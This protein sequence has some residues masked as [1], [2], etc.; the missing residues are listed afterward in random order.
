MYNRYDRLEALRIILSNHTAGSQEDIL[1]ELRGYGHEVTQATLSRDL[2][3]LK[4]VKV[5]SAE[6]YMYTLPEHKLYR[7]TV[8]SDNAAEYLRNTGFRGLDF[9]GNLAVLHTRE[10]YAQ[11]LA[12]DIDAHALPSVVGTI[13]GDDTILLVMAENA[14]QQ[15]L[16]DELAGVIPAMKS[17]ML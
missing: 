11:G 14:S 4:A 1:R 16:V 17:V 15:Q 5:R 7:R 10:G 9:S 8:S 12:S 3:K 2:Q 6:G 13:A